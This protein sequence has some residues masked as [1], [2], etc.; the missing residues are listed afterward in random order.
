MKLSNLAGEMKRCGVTIS[1][2][3]KLPGCSQRTVKN[4]ISG[5]SEFSFP[6]T[7]KIRAEFFPSDRLEYLFAPEEQIHTNVR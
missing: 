1:D 5:V 7:M 3:Q 4:K 6:E 2:I